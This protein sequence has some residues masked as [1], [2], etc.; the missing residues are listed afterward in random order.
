MATDPQSPLVV[1]GWAESVLF[2]GLSTLLLSPRHK[3]GL[4]FPM[5]KWEADGLS[6]PLLNML[7]YSWPL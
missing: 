3:A 7:E 5:G 2:G 1:K 4:A 6:K